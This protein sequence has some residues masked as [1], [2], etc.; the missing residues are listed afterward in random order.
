[1][2]PS[3]RPRGGSPSLDAPQLQLVHHENVFALRI[4]RR[5]VHKKTVALRRLMRDGV[6]MQLGDRFIGL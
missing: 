2:L 4:G 6:N 3:F 1:M 5:Y